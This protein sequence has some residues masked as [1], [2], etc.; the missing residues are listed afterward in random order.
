MLAQVS[1]GG[2]YKQ[3][4]EEWLCSGTDLGKKRKKRRKKCGSSAPL[5]AQNVNAES[6]TKRKPK[7]LGPEK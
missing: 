4:D 2:V 5:C 1:L 7:T 6:G 3:G